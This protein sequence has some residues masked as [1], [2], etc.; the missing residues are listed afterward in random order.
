M[1]ASI[2]GQNS[3]RWFVLRYGLRGEGAGA[4]KGIGGRGTDDN[5]SAGG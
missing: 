1:R 4:S 2:S 3:R 5:C